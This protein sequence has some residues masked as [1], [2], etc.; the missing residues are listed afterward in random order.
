[1]KIR[2]LMIPDPITIKEDATIDEAITVMKKSRIRH[3][4]VVDNKNNLKGFLTL[5]D[6]KQGLIPSMLSDITLSDLMIKNPITVSPEDDV[7]HAA[8]LIYENKIGGIP[9]VAGRRLVGIITESDILRAFIEILGMLYSTH[10]IELEI[11]NDNHSFLKALSIIKENGGEIINI[12]LKERN[13]LRGV[14]YFR[15]STMNMDNIRSELRCQGF[16][17][18]D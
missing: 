1:M 13:E 2:T 12:S 14:Y 7:E 5:A 8:R 9:V 4:P 3:L 17:I 10:S 6:L 15:I 11:G 18:L 16:N